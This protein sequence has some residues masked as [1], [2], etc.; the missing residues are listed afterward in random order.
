MEGRGMAGLAGE[1]VLSLTSPL[2]LAPARCGV[3]AAGERVPR[4]APPVRTAGHEGR[5]KEEGGFRRGAV[6]GVRR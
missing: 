2:I 6:A 5:V 4:Y 3:P 1:R